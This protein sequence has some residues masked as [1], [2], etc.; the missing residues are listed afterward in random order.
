MNPIERWNGLPD[1]EKR[2]LLSRCCGS[3]NW[4]EALLKEAPFSHFDA[5]IQRAREVWFSLGEA[6][7]L[8]AFSHHPRI[9]QR[10]EK[11]DG[12][13][14]QE[15]AGALLAEQEVQN[16]LAELN[17]SYEQRYGF[18]YLVC[19]TG[20]S[21]PELLLILKGRLNSTREDELQ[22]AAGEQFKISELRLRKFLVEC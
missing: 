22:V 8:E 9:G 7:W 13:E 14:S 10:P 21:G 3:K 4:V 18:I 2:E 16:E 12:M 20:K 11:K 17:R 19:A 6:D 15:Q 1:S 5:L